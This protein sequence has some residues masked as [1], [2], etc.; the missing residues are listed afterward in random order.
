MSHKICI[1][2]GPTASGKSQIALKIAEKTGAEIVSADSMLIYRGMDIG[3][4]KPC[5]EIRTKIPHH[6]IDIRDP[7]EEYSVGN[8]IKDFEIVT[9]NLYEQEKPFIVVGGTA[10]YLKAIMDGLFDG[11]PANWEY[12]NRLKTIAREQGTEYLYHMLETIDPKTASRL[13]S[14]DQRRIIRAL[15]VFQQTGISI[16]SYQTQFGNKNPKYHCIAVAIMHDR[17][18][19]YRRIESRVDDMFSRGLVDEVKTLMSNPLGLSKQAS[20]ALGYK[21]VIDLLRGNY[22]LP[23][24]V[25]AIKQ[26]TRRFAKRQMT[27]FRSFSDIHWV[28]ADSPENA[29]SLAESILDYFALKNP[30]LNKTFAC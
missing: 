6:L 24:A 11:P 25:N 4:E 30:A 21:E 7:W 18:E 14:N 5:A 15:E 20:Q 13:H 29:D 26:G 27:W 16:S 17:K 8:Y 9:N 23:D 1:L 3:T 22:L 12:R 2:T 19:L 10:L 28:T